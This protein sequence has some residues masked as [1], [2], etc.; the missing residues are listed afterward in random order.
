MLGGSLFEDHH[1]LLDHF[2]CLKI[3]NIPRS[4]NSSAHEL[5]KR[6]MSW[7][8]GQSYVW[9]DLLSEHVIGLAARDYAELESFTIRPRAE[10]TIKKSSIANYTYI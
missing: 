8:P 5:A 4:C 3:C 1:T 7:D 9:T 6:G 10:L 2:I